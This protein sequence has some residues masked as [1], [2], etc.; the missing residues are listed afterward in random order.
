[1]AV[2]FPIADAAERRPLAVVAEAG[3]LRILSA[4]G[5]EK[6][7]KTKLL[8]GRPANVHVHLLVAEVAVTDQPLTP[9]PS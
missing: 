3:Q 7:M 4:F 9:T 8:S 1:M 6:D 5:K 2:P